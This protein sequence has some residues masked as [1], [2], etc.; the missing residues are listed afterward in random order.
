MKGVRLEKA[1]NL[2]Y[3]KIQKQSA[4]LSLKMLT[5]EAVIKFIRKY[6]CEDIGERGESQ[7]VR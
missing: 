4:L 6:K 3:T 2:R 5:D 1:G 7:Y